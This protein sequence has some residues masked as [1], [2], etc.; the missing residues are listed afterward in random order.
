MRLRFPLQSLF[1]IVL[2]AIA[3]FGQSPNGTISGLVL[4][5]SGRAIVGADILDPER[6]HGVELS[7]GDERSRHLRDYQPSP[8]PL[9]HPGVET[10]D[11]RPS[12]SQ[13]SS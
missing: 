7:R 13:T 2:L 3:V 4:D 8:R 1:F 12:S 5:P 9:S 10:Q 6:R 11:S